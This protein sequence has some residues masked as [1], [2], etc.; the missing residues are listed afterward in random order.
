MSVTKFVTLGCAALVLLVW[1]LRGHLVMMSLSY[2]F[3]KSK[4][5]CGCNESPVND[6]FITKR[7]LLNLPYFVPYIG[8]YCLCTKV[9]IPRPNADISSDQSK[10]R[11][12]LQNAHD[13]AI[14]TQSKEPLCSSI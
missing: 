7:C 13:K 3:S 5:K 9:E 12:Y 2:I 11:T 6:L 4:E 14:K 1:F 10:V 8:E